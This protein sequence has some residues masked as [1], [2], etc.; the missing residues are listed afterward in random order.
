MATLTRSRRSGLKSSSNRRWVAKAETEFE[1]A[2]IGQ[3][4]KDDLIQALIV[5]ESLKMAK[6]RHEH[7]SNDAN[8]N[9]HQ[10]NGKNK[11]RRFLQ[12]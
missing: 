9:E 6:V 8:A 7:H 3:R 2:W 1:K 11:E 4:S 10:Q 12:K 5:C